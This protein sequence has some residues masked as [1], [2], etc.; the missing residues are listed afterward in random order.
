MRVFI[1]KGHI[2]SLKIDAVIA[3]IYEGE[4]ISGMAPAMPGKCKK[5]IHGIL[6]SSG[7]E[8][9]LYQ[10]L[11]LYPRN[12]IASPRVLLVGI[13]KK[14]DLSLDKI[15][16]A[17]SRAAQHLNA[18]KCRSIG[19]SIEF[20]PSGFAASSSEITEVLIEGAILGLYQF[21]RFKTVDK[22]KGVKIKKLYIV[23]ERT[24]CLPDIRAGAASAEAVTWAVVFARD[25][26]S[27]PSNEMTPRILAGEARQ[28]AMARGIGFRELNEKQMKKY[29]MDALL[30]VARG[31]DEEARLMILN[32]RG[33]AGSKRPVVL[34]GK[35]LT[36]DS[37]GISL[38]PAEKMDEM[39]SDMAGG[40]AVL[41]AI[42]AAADLRLPVNIVGI[43][44]ATENLPSGHAYKP[45]DILKS[46][47]GQT[48]EVLNTDAEGRLILADALTFACRYKPAAIIDLATLTGACIV[49]LGDNVIGMMGTDSALKEIMRH[50]GD[51]TGERV[52]ELPLWDDYEEQIKST[53]ADWKNSGGRPAGAI[54]AGMFLSKFVLSYP[55]I[56]LDIAG[57]AWLDK[58]KP[59]I[60]KGASGV[61]VRLLV[62]FLKKWVQQ[63]QS[64][65]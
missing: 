24:D 38:K 1:K 44:P 25:L 62:A 5:W 60:P 8:G 47:S 20:A 7:F 48:I 43:V 50:V 27:M 51:M 21:D 40:A 65:K 19:A 6:R 39:K 57:P 13:G 2:G 41:G 63:D 58:D 9:K 33:T 28:M 18:V 17:F 16:G 15:R 54:T 4:G 26:V 46:M 31:S 56:H 49:A 61:G 12:L 64:L 10:T 32:Y 59:Y 36:F 22:D 35:G 30:G 29:G 11:L 37:G 34:V 14:K 42:Q 53:I 55:W 52:W 3:M 23:H 45:G